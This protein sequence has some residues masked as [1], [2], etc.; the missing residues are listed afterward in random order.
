MVE[1]N[2]PRQPQKK[3]YLKDSLFKSIDSSFSEE[4]FSFA[5]SQTHEQIDQDD[6]N[7]ENEE[8][9]K[10]LNGDVTVIP[11]NRAPNE[12][13]LQIVLSRH[14]DDDLQEWRQRVVEDRSVR[15]DDVEGKG[16]SAQDWG[17]DEDEVDES[18]GDPERHV[19]VNS[20]TRKSADLGVNVVNHFTLVG[21]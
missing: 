5:D 14:H 8:D 19:D 2:N 16:V 7:E 20:N 17:E 13:L 15:V 21:S 18:L 6:R 10:K 3:I 9:E 11:F 4:F 12:I 1:D